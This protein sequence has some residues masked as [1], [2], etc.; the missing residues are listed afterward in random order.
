MSLRP[1]LRRRNITKVMEGN[2]NNFPIEKVVKSSV[3]RVL[4]FRVSP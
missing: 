4:E 2:S 3:P 1:V